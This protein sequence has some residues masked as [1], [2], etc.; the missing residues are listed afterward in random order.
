MRILF[1]RPAVTGRELD[2]ISDAINRGHLSGDGH[3]TNCVR[4]GSS[5]I[6]AA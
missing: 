2:Y 5:P 4:T 1:N 6:S 3:Y